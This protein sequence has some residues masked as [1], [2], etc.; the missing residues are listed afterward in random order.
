MHSS[1]RPLQLSKYEGEEQYLTRIE[2][3]QTPCACLSLE[4]K[5]HCLLYLHLSYA[6]THISLM[7]FVAW[8]CFNKV[9][10]MVTPRLSWAALGTTLGVQ[11]FVDHSQ[12]Y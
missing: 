10:T 4:K 8:V 9:V 12:F 6:F 5:V 3:S 2:E 11:G 1:L 7:S